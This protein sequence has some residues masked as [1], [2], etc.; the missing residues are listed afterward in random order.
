MK[1]NIRLPVFP[2]PAFQ[3]LLLRKNNLKE[4]K[5][6]KFVHLKN[7][8][9]CALGTEDIS[10][11]GDKSFSNQCHIAASALEAIIVPMAVLKRNESRAANTL[12]DKWAI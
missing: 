11:I 5:K 8:L 7:A 4:Q 2:L 9:L 12:K 3:G 10:A 6:K 1:N